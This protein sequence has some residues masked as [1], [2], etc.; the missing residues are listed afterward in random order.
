MAWCTDAQRSLF[1]LKSG[2]PDMDTLLYWITRMKPILALDSSQETIIV[3]GNRC[4]IEG[5]TTYVGTSTVLGIKSGEILLYGILGRDEEELLIVDTD[6]PPFAKLK[7]QTQGQVAAEDSEEDIPAPTAQQPADLQESEEHNGGS[8]KPNSEHR[9]PPL[10]DC[11]ELLFDRI[12]VTTNESTGQ[13]HDNQWLESSHHLAQYPTRGLPKVDGGSMGIPSSSSHASHPQL[14]QSCV[15]APATHHAEADE[16]R[17]AM[18]EGD[19]NNKRLDEFFDSYSNSLISDLYSESDEECW[20]RTQGSQTYSDGPRRGAARCRQH[21]TG[22]QT[23][24]KTQD[25]GRRHSPANRPQIR[26]TAERADRETASESSL[27]GR[28]A[29]V[30]LE[31]G[32]VPTSVA[33]NFDEEDIYKYIRG[34]NLT[35][36]HHIRYHTR[37]RKARRAKQGLP[38]DG[39]SE[40]EYKEQEEERQNERQPY[41]YQRP[42]IH[43]N[44]KSD[45]L[46]VVESDRKDLLMLA[47]A[48]HSRVRTEQ[49]AVP[50]YT[51]FRPSNVRNIPCNEQPAEP[52]P[53]ADTPMSHMTMFSQTRTRRRHDRQPSPL[54]MGLVNSRNAGTLPLRGADGSLRSRDVSAGRYAGRDTGWSRNASGNGS[55]L[56]FA[57]LKVKE[58][59][60]PLQHPSRRPKAAGKQVQPLM[61]VPREAPK[62]KG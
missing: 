47:P 15:A 9:Q 11:P 24:H 56:A 60:I 31:N 26:P 12:L 22:T 28:I 33:E 43:D 53:I 42:R 20:P 29:A 30:A 50:N 13:Q 45:R 44:Y 61:L 58:N 52:T 40:E 6:D 62:E 36:E 14:T 8:S 10:T 55:G 5:D 38:E 18:S 35:S 19:Y 1:F 48:S 25:T 54:A 49:N 59:L 27:V 4:G 39:D 41:E 7:L 17:P 16:M 23:D 32:V 21:H 3:F 34:K 2:E 46:P 51:F 37:L 57:K